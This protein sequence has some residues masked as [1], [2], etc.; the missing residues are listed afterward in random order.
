MN[1]FLILRK[2]FNKQ[3]I[4]KEKIRVLSTKFNIHI[5]KRDDLYIFSTGRSG[6]TWLMELLSYDS[7]TRFVNE[8]FGIKFIQNS[9]LNEKSQLKD[10]F[11]KVRFYSMPE[12]EITR[13]YITDP[14]HTKICGPYNIFKGNYHFITHKRL[15]KILHLNPVL[16]ELF[17][18]IDPNPNVFLIRHPVPNILSIMKSYPLDIESFLKSKAILSLLNSS[19]SEMIKSIIRRGTIYEKWAIQWSLDQ[20]V[21]FQLVKN[22]KLN[23]ISYEQLVV[24]PNPVLD[25]LEKHFNLNNVDKIRSHL[26]DPSASTSYNKINFIKS[27][28]NREK[29]SKWR[30]KVNQSIIEDIFSIIENFEIDYYSK[31]SDMP[32]EKYIIK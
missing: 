25:Y 30:Q 26:K 13:K 3:Y 29:I 21:P 27:A 28:S 16:N 15:F 22:G 5:N 11:R 1:I 2:L 7:K 14:K 9:I 31:H 24:E 20:L 10:H 8:P 12:K 4:L 19:Q 17:E 18:I 6:S 32:V 23:T